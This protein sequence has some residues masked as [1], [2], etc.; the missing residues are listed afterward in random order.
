MSPRPPV[1]GDV[2]EILLIELYANRNLDTGLGQY[3]VR[4][5]MPVNTDGGVPYTRT[6]SP[7]TLTLTEAVD[8]T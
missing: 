1:Y 6:E 7:L 2:K 4:S 3:T 8:G 5:T